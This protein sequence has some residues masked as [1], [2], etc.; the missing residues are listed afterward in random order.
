MPHLCTQQTAYLASPRTGKNALYHDA[1]TD[2]VKITA[3]IAYNE[4]EVGLQDLS[5]N[6]QALWDV[7]VVQEAVDKATCEEKTH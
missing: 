5:P 6:A 2:T 3:D 1:V 4:A 7:G